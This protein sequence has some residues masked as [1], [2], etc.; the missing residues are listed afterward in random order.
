MR[1]EI[2]VQGGTIGGHLRTHDIALARIIM[3]TLSKLTKEEIIIYDVREC[4]IIAS[5]NDKKTDTSA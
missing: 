5:S 2:S 1:Y 3:D 4:G